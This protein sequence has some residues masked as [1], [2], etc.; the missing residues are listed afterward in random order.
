MQLDRLRRIYRTEQRELAFALFF[1][2]NKNHLFV[3]TCLIVFGLGYV[4]G[5][6]VK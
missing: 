5:V 4:F 1:Q 2:K 6:F 3:L